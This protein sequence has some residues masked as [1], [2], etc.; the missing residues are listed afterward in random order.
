MHRK[1][2]KSRFLPLVAFCA[3]FL[4]AIW[5]LWKID[6]EAKE[7]GQGKAYDK[8]IEAMAGLTHYYPLDKQNEA[9]DIVGG[10]NG[11]SHKAEF[12]AEGAVFDGWSDIEIPDN[13]DFSVN[14]TGELTIVVFQ[15]VKDWR[16]KGGKGEFINWLGKGQLD[17]HEWTFRHYVLGGTGEASERPKRTSFYC[18]NP[19]GNLGSGAYFQDDDPPMVERMIVAQVNRETVRIW[20]DGK[21]RNSEPLSASMLFPKTL[22]ALFALE[23]ETKRLVT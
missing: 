13:D 3:I 17:Q 21:F 4:Y 1:L 15:T 9:N 12:T 10:I 18:F 22:L 8:A 16:G 14:N 7:I 11:E 5:S 23:R 2:T 20:K 6:P 19:G